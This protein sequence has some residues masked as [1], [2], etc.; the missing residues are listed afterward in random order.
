ME[1]NN[2]NVSKEVEVK[3][4]FKGGVIG[5]LMSNYGLEKFLKVKKSNFIGLKLEIDNKRK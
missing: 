2:C 1:S 3:K 5:T 4:N